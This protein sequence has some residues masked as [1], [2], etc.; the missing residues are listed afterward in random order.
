M[1]LKSSKKPWTKSHSVSSLWSLRGVF[2]PSDCWSVDHYK[3]TGSPSKQLRLTCCL[4]LIRN[5]LYLEAKA[6]NETLARFP[7]PDIKQ[8]LFC[9]TKSFCDWYAAPPT[10][11]LVPLNC[12]W[13]GNVVVQGVKLFSWL[14]L[15]TRNH[16]SLQGRRSNF[17]IILYT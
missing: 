10:G 2:I 3:V 4:R 12:C 6:S 17:Y 1:N 5:H 9:R 14:Q 15:W 8:A 7:R 16:D 11:L 13:L